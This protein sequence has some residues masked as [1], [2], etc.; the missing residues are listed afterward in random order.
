MDINLIRSGVTVLSLV[1]FLALVAWTW[2]KSR[3]NAFDEAADLPFA[4]DATTHTTAAG[5]PR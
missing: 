3:R 2:N 5:E 1:M 4:D